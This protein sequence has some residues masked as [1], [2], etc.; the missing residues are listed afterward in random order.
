MSH[1]FWMLA[2][3]GCLAGDSRVLS[4]NL[5]FPA[6]HSLCS[7]TVHDGMLACRT[8]LYETIES[9]QSQI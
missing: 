5:D 6:L 3:W 1:C 2:V 4:T 7:A 8:A 9:L